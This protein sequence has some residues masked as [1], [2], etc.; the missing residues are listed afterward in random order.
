MPIAKKICR[1][2][3]KSYEAC[4]SAKRN[5]GVFHWQEVACSPECGTEYLRMVNEAR[6]PVAKAPKVARHT[7]RKEPEEAVIMSHIATKPVTVEDH[8]DVQNEA[9][10]SAD[11]ATTE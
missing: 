9:D 10:E 6:N 2:C 4:R 11:K 1:V 8:A 5:A 7:K 3:G